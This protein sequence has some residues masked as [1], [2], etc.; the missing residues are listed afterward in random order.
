MKYLS[1]IVLFFVG[2]FAFSQ[3]PFCA[4]NFTGNPGAS[5]CINSVTLGSYVS[6][7]DTSFE[8]TGGYADHTLIPVSICAG[9]TYEIKVNVN[10]TVAWLNNPGASAYVMAFFDWNDDGELNGP[11]EAIHI[12]EVATNSSPIGVNGPGVPQTAPPIDVTGVINVPA[13]A[14]KNFYFRVVIFLENVQTTCEEQFIG[15]VEEFKANFRSYGSL[16]QQ[17]TFITSFDNETIN[18]TLDNPADAIAWQVD[19]GSGFADQAGFNGLS[20][21]AYQT[22]K[23]LNSVR[24]YTTDATCITDSSSQT[25]A[26]SSISN[27]VKLGSDEITATPNFACQNDSV[28]TFHEFSNELTTIET[29]FPTTTTYYT[30]PDTSLLEVDVQDEVMD[31]STLSKVCVNITSNAFSDLSLILEAPNGEK[32]IL[33][34]RNGSPFSPTVATSEFCFSD[35]IGADF[36]NGFSSNLSGTYNP[37]QSLDIFN[38]LDPSGSWKMLMTTEYFENASHTL[39]SWSMEFGH[40]TFVGWEAPDRFSDASLDSARVQVVV[41]TVFRAAFESEYGNTNLDSV[42]VL[43]VP[44][45]DVKLNQLTSDEANVCPG[46]SSVFRSTLATGHNNVYYEWYLNGVL[47]TGE[48]EDTIFIAGLSDQ[49]VVKVIADVQSTCNTSKDSLEIIV[50]GPTFQEA[51]LSVSQNKQFPL[52]E[53]EDLLVS[54]DIQNGDPNF[55]SEWLVNNLSQSQNTASYNWQGV[56]DNDSL[57]YNY[58]QTNVC[59]DVQTFSDTIVYE[60]VVREDLDVTM[61]FTNGVTFCQSQNLSF[62]VNVNDPN[63]SATYTWL[64]DGDDLLNNKND[65]E[66]SSLSVG[67]HTIDVV[68]EPN[69]GCY[70]QQN[71]VATVQFEIEKTKPTVLEVAGNEVYCPGASVV[72]NI[73]DSINIGSGALYKWFENGVEMPSE[74]NPGLTLATPE[75]GKTYTLEAISDV[76]CASPSI[77]MSNG[78]VLAETELTN[79]S[80][81]LSNEFDAEYCEKTQLSNSVILSG[82]ADV[83]IS[84]WNLN[85]TQLQV[86]TDLEY[87]LTEGEHVLEFVYDFDRGCDVVESGKIE[88]TFDVFAP[89]D[90]IFTVSQNSVEYTVDLTNAIDE[91]N[92]NYEWILDGDF[93]SNDAEPVFE[94]VEEG[95]YTLCMT[96]TKGA[97][98]ICGVQKCLEFTY[99]G[100]DNLQFSDAISLFPNPVGDQLMLQ[101]EFESSAQ[102]RIININGKNVL[103][104]II[105]LT[106]SNID[107]SSLNSGSYQI[108]V[109]DNSKVG[110]KRFVKM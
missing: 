51:T 21:I 49:D 47:Q 58:T 3:S 24:A 45:E 102:Y 14:S 59:G 68:Y 40:Q 31:F 5:L 33:S 97:S 105:E 20:T 13:S 90:T 34:K 96:A 109:I 26:Y 107:V 65:Y 29:T 86:G 93:L 88:R 9:A 98:E 44:S 19:N 106:N 54:V 28:S 22:K 6:H 77:I 78:I 56:N 10:R 99:I 39:N 36:I 1:L 16:D 64:L 80:A 101:G 46:A 23:G 30:S 108:I 103:T 110:V 66:S 43:V 35:S 55:S 81:A 50:T 4:P 8:N 32:L 79:L 73:S 74:T 61:N 85:G 87:T 41:D 52:C 76:N 18:L 11:N 15:E 25:R 69:G 75:S 62:F 82:D 57:I 7:P 94:L 42:T 72:L 89:A 67:S 27:F 12:G 92:A 71:T 83:I 84:Q 60:G 91:A 95:D 2:Q 104:G 70:N 100:I 37:A 63:L 48:N 53:N 38:G 17:N